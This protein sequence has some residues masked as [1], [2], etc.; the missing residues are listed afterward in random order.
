VKY[1]GG[2]VTAIEEKW[3]TKELKES[4]VL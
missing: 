4:T 3:K 2:E 1:G